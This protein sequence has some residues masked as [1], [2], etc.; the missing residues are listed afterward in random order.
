M[1]DLSKIQIQL[2]EFA[3][4]RDW[5]QFHSP[6]NLSMAIAS[7]AGELLELF[8]WLSVP[9]SSH[10]MDDPRKAAAVREE[11]AD[12]LIYLV[13]LADILK[14]DLLHVADQKRFISRYLRFREAVCA[15]SMYLIPRTR[16]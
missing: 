10:I 2:R 7:E 9:E 3:R 12:V 13:R 8:Q 1:D 15:R 6:K 11:I 5:E 16:I 4:E 14:I